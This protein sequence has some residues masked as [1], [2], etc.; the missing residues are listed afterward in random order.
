MEKQSPN[1]S[2]VPSFDNE[3]SNILSISDISTRQQKFDKL[4]WDIKQAFPKD[5]K[6]YLMRSVFWLLLK[7]LKDG[8]MNDLSVLKWL[9]NRLNMNADEVIEYFII[10]IGYHSKKTSQI[11]KWK[12]SSIKNFALLFLSAV[13]VAW[14]VYSYNQSQKIEQLKKQ[15]SDIENHI[16]PDTNKVIANLMLDLCTD[17]TVDKKNKSINISS[18]KNFC[19]KNLGLKWDDRREIM[20]NWEK[21][22]FLT[23]YST[24]LPKLRNA[25]IE[26]LKAN[27]D[28]SWIKIICKLF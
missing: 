6:E 23:K 24:Q 13:S 22:K 3:I 19:E 14:W 20:T 17:L 2:S 21:E 18:T 9:W 25:C 7:F 11:K 10:F 12:N 1:A 5:Y 27:P 8:N 26:A 4:V 15:V 28:D 16:Q